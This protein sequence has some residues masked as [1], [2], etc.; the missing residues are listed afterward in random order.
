MSSDSEWVAVMPEAQGHARRDAARMLQWLRSDV[1]RRRRDMAEFHRRA[2]LSSNSDES[3]TAAEQQ[4]QQPRQA[5][6]FSSEGCSPL[7]RALPDWESSMDTGR[8]SGEDQLFADEP[9]ALVD[10][11]RSAPFVRSHHAVA[12]AAPDHRRKLGRWNSS[13]QLRRQK[14]WSP[15]KDWIPLSKCGDRHLTRQPGACR[16]PKGG[17]AEPLTVDQAAHRK[18]L[19]LSALS[20]DTRVSADSSLHY[21]DACYD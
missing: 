11:R 6:L 10:F 13:P 1:L 12:A 15:E 18:M 2:S 7:W 5:F 14:A 19:L 17:A 4:Q 21:F 9:R 16:R 8:S 3:T 20:V